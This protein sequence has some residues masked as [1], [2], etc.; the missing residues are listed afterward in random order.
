MPLASPTRGGVAGSA[1]ALVLSASSKQSF[2]WFVTTPLRAEE[3]LEGRP[4]KQQIQVLGCR[5]W[6]GW[7]IRSCWA[8]PLLF[9]EKQ[10]LGKVRLGEALPPRGRS[11]EGSFSDDGGA[12]TLPPV[13]AVGQTVECLPSS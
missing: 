4:T 6:G 8:F 9:P 13:S 2:L 7:D 5:E 12:A 10:L 1:G 11:K 3:D